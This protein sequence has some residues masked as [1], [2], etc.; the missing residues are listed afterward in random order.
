MCSPT[1]I[2]LVVSIATLYGWILGRADAKAA[3]LQTRKAQRS[4]YVKSPRESSMRGTHLWLLLTASYG[5]VNANAKWQYQSDQVLEELGLT[6]SVHIPQLFYKIENGKLVFILAKI[7]DDIICAG[8]GNSAEIFLNKVNEHF[9]L[10]TIDCRKGEH[11]FFGIN[12]TQHEYYSITTN[13]DDKLNDLMEYNFL[14]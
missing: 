14:E 2:R 8:I 7:V 13:A 6:Q 5:L 3:F 9:K 4:V 12:V 11:R 10:G 1:G